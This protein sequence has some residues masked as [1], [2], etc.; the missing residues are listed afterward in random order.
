MSWLKWGASSPE[1]RPAQGR[2]PL[3]SFQL[4]TE[5]G[6][7]DWQMTPKCGEKV[8]T[9]QWQSAICP[10]LLAIRT[11]PDVWIEAREAMIH[12]VDSWS[13]KVRWLGSWGSRVATHQ[14]T[15]WLPPT[16]C[17]LWANVL[18]WSRFTISD[19]TYLPLDDTPF[20]PSCYSIA[21]TLTHL[22]A[23]NS[24]LHNLK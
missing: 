4:R 17:H 22:R 15:S 13:D 19:Y 14:P 12:F 11:N 24:N 6:V 2:R 5:C 20:L 9:V 7:A 1:S 23:Y 8:G 16:R 3:N 10:A 21:L 18:I